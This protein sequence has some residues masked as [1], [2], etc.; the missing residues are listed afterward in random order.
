[1]S[2]SP[3]GMRLPRLDLLVRDIESAIIS[4]D[5]ARQSEL[6]LRSAAA[7]TRHWSRLPVA[8]KPSFDRLLASLLDQVDLEARATFAQCLMPLRR[9][10]RITTT[11]LACDSSPAVSMSLLEHCPSF[12]DAWLL[13]IIESVGPEHQLAMAR[14]RTLGPGLTDSL[15]RGGEPT[16]AAALLTN[17]G[18]ALSAG[19]LDRLLTGAAGSLP[20]LLALANRADLSEAGR[21][22]LAAIARQ[23]ASQA[24]TEEG[25]F[26]CEEADTLLD[27]VARTFRAPVCSEDLARHVASAAV[28]GRGPGAKPTRSLTIADWLDRRR[29][30]DVL[31]TL[32]RDVDLPVAVLIACRDAPMPHALT[33]IMRGLGHPWSLLKALLQV[34]ARGVVAPECLGVAHR[35]HFEI[36]PR[37]A[38]MVARYAAIQSGTGAFVA[39]AASDD[40]HHRT[41]VARASGG[42]S[43]LEP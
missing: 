40:R 33:I 30:E 37:T 35:L 27:H 17:P 14:R 32:A 8:D 18:A 26:S 10:P 36:G 16:I 6:V 4:K 25:E 29:H 41:L 15:L 22:A 21:A 23:S 38:R 24:L 31:A 7:L 2:A 1:M 34:A 19:A 13:Q 12:D 5:R 3:G 43:P 28:A 42:T 39:A 11:R 20:L 9:A